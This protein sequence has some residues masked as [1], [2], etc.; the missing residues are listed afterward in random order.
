MSLLS[1]SVLRTE[2]HTWQIV[3]SG[4]SGRLLKITLSNAA[5]ILY[6]SCRHYYEWDDY[7]TFRLHRPHCCTRRD[8]NG[9]LKCPTFASHEPKGWAGG[10]GGNATLLSTSYD[11]S[12][13]I[14]VLSRK[15]RSL[16]SWEDPEYDVLGHGKNSVPH[17]WWGP[18]SGAAHNGH[19][20]QLKW[21]SYGALLRN[22]RTFCWY[23]WPLF[24]LREIQRE[25]SAVSM[26]F[27]L[28]K[29]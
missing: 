19:W 9:K 16:E 27:L 13:A 15:S 22:R 28:W 29:N 3:P 1:L 20:S 14:C 18:L 11:F 23:K 12:S 24:D 21:Q 6:V 17:S 25:G 10:V 7:S 8:W 5:L 26:L 4:V 2:R